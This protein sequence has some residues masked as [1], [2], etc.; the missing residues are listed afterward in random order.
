[1]EAYSQ[2]KDFLGSKGLGVVLS[3]ADEFQQYHQK[4]EQD[5]HSEAR[6]PTRSGFTVQLQ[7]IICQVRQLERSL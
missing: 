4:V 2:I 6:G 3:T 1:M 5:L 7:D